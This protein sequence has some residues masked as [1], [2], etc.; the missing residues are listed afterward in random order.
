MKTLV[1]VIAYNEG[2]NISNVIKDLVDHN[3]GYDIVVIDNASTD[4]TTQVC[5]QKNIKVITHI[6][7]TGGSFGT[8]MTY[9]RYAYE[10]NYDILCQFDGDGQHMASELPKIINPVANNEADYMIGSRFLEKEGFQS[11]FFRRMGIRFF[12]LLDSIIIGHHV[13]DVTSG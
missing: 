5:K 9:F 4:H 11:Y 7:N 1:A 3:I 10:N 8:V 12:G 13:T 6:V 2:Q